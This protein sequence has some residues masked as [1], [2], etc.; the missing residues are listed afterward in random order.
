[1]ST[2]CVVFSHGKESGPWGTK[3]TALA[4]VARVRGW[5]VESVDYRGLD[6][7]EARLEALHAACRGLSA[8]TVLV[9]SSLGGWLAAAAS[10]GV[11]V[12]GR[13]GRWV[14]PSTGAEIAI[15]MPSTIAEMVRGRIDA[16][17][18]APRRLLEAA[19]VLGRE[20]ETALLAA[21]VDDRR[22]A[23]AAALD[24]AQ[25]LEP[26]SEGVLR[27]RHAA[28]F[29]RW[30]PDKAPKDCRY[31]QLEVTAPYELERVFGAGGASSSG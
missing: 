15:S 10:A 21:C 20:V 28:I 14:L 4:E 18:A 12:R 31:D 29:R 22:L 27:F 13:D 23:G 19:A 25:L 3:I 30:R 1:M 7:V 17:D 2:R 6:R 9:G 26:V 24:A 16:L 5:A 11:L 8:P